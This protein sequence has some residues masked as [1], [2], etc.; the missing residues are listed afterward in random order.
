MLLLYTLR[1]VLF[2]LSFQV[3]IVL[4]A[5]CQQ[6]LQV[7]T[8]LLFIPDKLFNEIN[9]KS[10]RMQYK[11]ESSTLN[12]LNK[13]EKTERRLKRRL[14]KK[15]SAAAIEIFGNTATTYANYK[16]LLSEVNDGGQSLYSSRIDSMKSAF[17]FL[18]YNKLLKQLPGVDKHIESG[19][20][21]LN[22]LQDRL[23]STENI[24]K[25]ILERQQY[26]MSKLQG[27]KM[28]K[29]LLP[30]KKQAYY[31]KQQL[32]VYKDIIEDPMKLVHPF[33]LDTKCFSFFGNG[34]SCGLSCFG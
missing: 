21:N 32:K 28:E 25:A 4:K 5:S 18:N 24:Q 29:Y 7:E 8:G 16:K 34:H 15:D 13:M 23:N 33:I 10:Q 3:I 14:A 19:L 11:L 20:N 6:D 31:Y 30:Y 1:I 2:F 27:F 9:K 12:Y 17:N 26:L 22:G